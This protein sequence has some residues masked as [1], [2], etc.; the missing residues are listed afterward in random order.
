MTAA[1]TPFTARDYLRECGEELLEAVESFELSEDDIM[2]SPAKYR[3]LPRKLCAL[4][5]KIKRL[6]DEIHAIHNKLEGV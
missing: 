1:Y 4:A 2:D 3:H 5:H 6:T